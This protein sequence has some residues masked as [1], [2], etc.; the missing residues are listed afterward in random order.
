MPAPVSDNAYGNTSEEDQRQFRATRG[1][2][3]PRRRIPNVGRR[4]NSKPKRR[5]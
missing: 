2:K 5:K 4:N 1:V 3:G